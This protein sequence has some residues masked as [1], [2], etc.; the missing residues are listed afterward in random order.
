MVQYTHEHLVPPLDALNYLLLV[1]NQSMYCA[2]YTGLSGQFTPRV[3]HSCFLMER[4]VRGKI[5]HPQQ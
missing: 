4:I 3:L 2:E 1:L 5:F